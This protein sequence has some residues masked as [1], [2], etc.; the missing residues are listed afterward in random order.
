MTC[1]RLLAAIAAIMAVGAWAAVHAQDV[2]ALSLPVDCAMGS[3]CYV[4]Q[5]FDH[6][7]GPG[8]VDYACGPLAYDGH[9]GTDIRTR[10]LAEM[11]EGVPV[12]AAAPG[13]VLETR[14]EMEDVSVADIGRDALQG[15]D[16]GNAV[17]INHGG[18]WF[19]QYSHLMKGSVSVH[20]GER[21]EAGQVLGMIGLSGNT[22]FPH[23]EFSVQHDGKDIDPFVGE[24]A[25]YACGDARAPL[26]TADAAAALTYVPGGALQAG[27]AG[28]AADYRD[29]REGAYDGFVLEGDTPALVFWAEFFGVRR[30][31]RIRLRLE[32][33][34]DYDTIQDTVSMSRDRAQQFQFVGRRRPDL[35]WPTGVYRGEA[36][37]LR[38][39]DGVEQV[40]AAMTE[41]IELR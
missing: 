9:D 7:P 10:T 33:P 30:H 40:V 41:A 26:W 28:G 17:G 13:V 5:Y 22:E 11:R 21:V 16:A 37:L 18:G 3:A 24:A 27:F 36:Q 15:R 12:L 38:T 14:D 31:D 19:T 29:A 39:I 32:F 20:V 4:Q 25:G 35:G 1:G 34:D 8:A 6:D 2:P 23:V